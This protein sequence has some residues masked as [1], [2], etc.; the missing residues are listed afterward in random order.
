MDSSRLLG[1]PFTR[2]A[3]ESANLFRIDNVKLERS[4]K[5]SYASYVK[6]MTRIAASLVVVVIGVSFPHP[7]HAQYIPTTTEPIINANSGLC[8]GVD[9]GTMVAGQGIIQWECEAATAAPDQYWNFVSVGDGIYE[10]QNYKNTDYCLGG[11]ITETGCPGGTECPGGGGAQMYIDY[12]GGASQDY[13]YITEGYG[14]DVVFTNYAIGLVAAAWEASTEEGTWVITW[15]DE[16]DGI[17]NPSHLEQQWSI[18]P[19]L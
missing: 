16:I 14:F 18:A 17:V 5:M 8:M 4:D 10:I 2:M 1:P 6:R 19:T 3:R 9:G 13:W 15:E 11:A 12:C 7:A